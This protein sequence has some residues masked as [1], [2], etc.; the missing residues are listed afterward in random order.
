M[1]EKGEFG[2][3]KSAPCILEHWLCHG[4]LARDEADS[5]LCFVC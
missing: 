1:R 2:G 5:P 3:V 4:G